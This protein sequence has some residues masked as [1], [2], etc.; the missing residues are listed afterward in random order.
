MSNY[1]VI[2]YK[3]NQDHVIYKTNDFIESIC[4]A[5]SYA[6][7]HHLKAS[8]KIQDNVLVLYKKKDGSEIIEAV[9]VI[10]E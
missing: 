4:V 9:G 7:H 8:K 5:K 10:S 3:N 1:T 2:V 6:N